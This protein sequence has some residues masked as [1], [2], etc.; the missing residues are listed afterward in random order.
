MQ[1]TGTIARKLGVDRD[2]VSYAIRKLGIQPKATAG[3]TRVFGNH[4]LSK[5]R[6]YLERKGKAFTIIELLTV[7]SIF[8]ILIGIMATATTAVRRYARQV[9]Q[10]SQFHE[11]GK[12]LE[13]FSVDFGGYPDSSATDFYGVPYCGAMKLCEALV[14][15]DGLGFHPLSKFDAV[16]TDQL[17]FNRPA[18]PLADPP[19]PAQEQSLQNWRKLYLEGKRNIQIAD[20]NDIFPGQSTFDRY[21]PVFCDVFKQN[22]I[23]VGGKKAGMPVLYYKASRVNLLHDVR[24]LAGPYNPGN[25][26]FDYYDNYDIIEE[27][28]PWLN[29]NHPF[30]VPSGFKVEGEL[31]YDATRNENIKTMRKPHNPNSYILISAGYDGLYGTEDDVFNFER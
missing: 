29:K 15:Q 7:M 24:Q 20:I 12:A 11:M 8:I 30:K 14:G 19:T 31:F 22:Q 18:N 2:R 25:N 23:Q 27:G 5:V 3:L 9:S 28:V 26:I 4:V 1:T 21:C 16:D 13:M 17:Y 6:K 10:K